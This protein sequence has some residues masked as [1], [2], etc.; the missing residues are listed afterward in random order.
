MVKQTKSNNQEEVRLRVTQDFVV[1]LRGNKGET[2]LY[3]TALSGYQ[4]FLVASE[5]SQDSANAGTMQ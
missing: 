1:M 4:V 5:Y 2:E 3:Q